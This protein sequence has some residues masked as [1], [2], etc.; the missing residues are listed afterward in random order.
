MKNLKLLALALVIGTASLFANNTSVLDIPAKQVGDQVSEL[1]QA[2][3]FAVEKEEVVRTLFTFDS[4]G[5]I[6]IINIA[7]SKK[8]VKDYIRKT[9]ENQIIPT[10]GEENRVFSIPIS[11]KR[12]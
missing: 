10:P 6:V 4:E 2:P 8:E 3:E 5:K 9:M 11:I 12:W 1:F 7:S